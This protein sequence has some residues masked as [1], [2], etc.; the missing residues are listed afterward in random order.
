MIVNAQHIIL[1]VK[2]SDLMTNRQL[3]LLSLIGLI[4][5]MYSIRGF[6]KMQKE[7]F[8]KRG[9][10]LNVTDKFIY[11]VRLSSQI[12]VIIML[13][14]LFIYSIKEELFNNSS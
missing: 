9:K 1:F 4:V 2:R 7:L 13:L 11:Y 10:Q 14:M 3:M 12:I 5:M 8:K 6:L